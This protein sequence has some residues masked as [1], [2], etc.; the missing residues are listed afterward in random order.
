MSDLHAAD[1]ASQP[2]QP[3]GG[4]APGPPPADEPLGSED[5]V[6]ADAAAALGA[7]SVRVV[8]TDTL[9]EGVYVVYRGNPPRLLV[10]EAWWRRARP[11]ERIQALET[12][13][14]RL[15]S[16]PPDSWDNV[17]QG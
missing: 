13:W 1:A 15:R 16:I 11:V 10:N 7:A 8:Y 5:A 4:P 9:A 14:A 17:A 12:L 6:A 3:S 2:D